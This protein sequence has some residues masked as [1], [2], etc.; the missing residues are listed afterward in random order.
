MVFFRINLKYMV[1]AIKIVMMRD[2]KIFIFFN[3]KTPHE[4]IL[5]LVLKYERFAYL[6]K[7]I[8][9]V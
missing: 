8:Y 7:V 3:M 9:N 1:R 5:D 2:K 4:I 6:Y